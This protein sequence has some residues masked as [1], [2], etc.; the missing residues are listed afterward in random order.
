M[1]KGTPTRPGLITIIVACT[2]LPAHV[3]AA[4]KLLHALIIIHVKLPSSS[5]AAACACTVKNWPRTVSGHFLPLTDTG[6][7]LPGMAALRSHIP[8][9]RFRG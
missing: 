1:T 8:T 5:S 7:K 6:S 9:E 3:C 2:P 4:M